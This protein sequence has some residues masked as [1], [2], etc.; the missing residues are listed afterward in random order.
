MYSAV[1]KREAEW[2]TYP[3]GGKKSSW[4]AAGETKGLK[5]LTDAACKHSPHLLATF[6][7]TPAKGGLEK[8]VVMS[9]LPGVLITAELLADANAAWKIS[10]AFLTA[11]EYVQ[12]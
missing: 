7:R 6:D 10:G 2:L 11:I 3:S 5:K 4:R 8:Y 1:P 9:K 12:R